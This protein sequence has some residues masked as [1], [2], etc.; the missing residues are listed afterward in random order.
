MPYNVTVS[1]GDVADKAA[2][3]QNGVAELESQLS[4]LTTAMADL[5][6]TWTGPA[7]TAFQNAYET[8]KGTAQQTKVALD[9]IGASLRNAG[10]QYDENEDALRGQ[11]T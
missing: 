7:S 8:W 2:T 5:A 3:I 6:G 1:T 4:M 9:D 11:W 10:T